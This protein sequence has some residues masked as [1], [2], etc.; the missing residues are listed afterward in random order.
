VTRSAVEQ[1]AFITTTA[2]GLDFDSF[3][4][5]LF[6]K[7]KR[8]GVWDP[9]DIDFAQDHEDWLRLATEEREALMQQVAL[10]LAGEESVTLDLL[11]LIMVVA[12]EGRQEGRIEE[13]MYLTSFLW[14]EAKHVEG[15]RRFCDAVAHDHSDLSR[16]HGPN[17]RRIFY[18]ELPTAMNRLKTDSSPVAQAR[19][20]VTYNMIVE[21]VLAETGYHSYHQTLTRHGLMP[22]M[23]Q[24]VGYVKRDESRHIAFAVYFLSRL[25]ARHG[26]VA[27]DAIEVRMNE[28]LPYAIGVID[29]SFD[30]F[31]GHPPFGVRKDSL[32]DYAVAQFRKRLDRIAHARTQSLDEVAAMADETGGGLD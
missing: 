31:D 27:W 15:F 4:M 32:I 13:E 10:F 17:Y 1:R 20:S 18:D 28:L 9:A 23:Q 3:P 7:S 26:A 29:D 12:Q 22:G 16:F 8:L 30:L 21:G 2:H 11:P 25:V 19:A 6:Q 24:L 5:R 14:E